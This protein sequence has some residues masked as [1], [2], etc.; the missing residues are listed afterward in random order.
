MHRN[1]RVTQVSVQPWQGVFEAKR[2]PVW[3]PC[4]VRCG[5]RARGNWPHRQAVSAHARSDYIIRAQWPRPI[6]VA[7]GVPDLTPMHDWNWGRAG[8]SDT[9]LGISKIPR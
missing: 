6:D 2:A 8:P 5:H 3:G 1:Y 9:L 4:V 7:R